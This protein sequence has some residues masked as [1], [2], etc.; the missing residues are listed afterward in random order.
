M[1]DVAVLRVRLRLEVELPLDDARADLGILAAAFRWEEV[2]G[3]SVDRVDIS[4]AD[5]E[6]QRAVGRH[7][8]IAGVLLQARRAPYRTGVLVRVAD[9]RFGKDGKRLAGFAGTDLSGRGSVVVVY[10]EY[11]G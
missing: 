2:A 11:G 3:V 5:G 8:A 4:T 1:E 7:L 9:W 6:R 10:V